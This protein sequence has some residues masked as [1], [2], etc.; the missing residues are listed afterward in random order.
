ME[1]LLCLIIYHLPRYYL[2]IKNKIIP[3]RMKKMNDSLTHLKSVEI[4]AP[5]V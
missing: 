4:L 2:P 1:K 3:E 5:K